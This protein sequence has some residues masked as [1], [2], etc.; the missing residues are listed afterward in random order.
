MKPINAL[1]V[2]MAGG[3]AT[4]AAQNAYFP[5]QA[6]AAAFV[7]PKGSDWR[8]QMLEDDPGSGAVDSTL[9]RLADHL[10]LTADQATK[11]RPLLQQRHERVL[12]LLLTAPPSLT[13]DQF[14]AQRRQINAEMHQQ[15]GALLT[16][17]QRLLVAELRT[18]PARL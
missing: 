7:V 18:Q 3:V 8:R 6:H 16:P 13:R 17:D 10:E 1:I 12:A 11:V 14:V 9:S 15:I 2:A 4:L 5:P